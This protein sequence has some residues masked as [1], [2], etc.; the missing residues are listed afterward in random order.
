MEA[1]GAAP[2]GS[3]E[4]GDTRREARARHLAALEEVGQEVAAF[5]RALA[6]LEAQSSRLGQSWARL[7]R[8]VAQVGLLE[9]AVYDAHVQRDAGATGP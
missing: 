6:R 4:S 7:E 5:G 3:G 1:G 8:G 9:S 2:A